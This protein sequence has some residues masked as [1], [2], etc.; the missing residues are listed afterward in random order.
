MNRVHITFGIII[1]ILL[2]VVILALQEVSSGDNNAELDTFAQCLSD[3][4][5]VMYGTYSCPYCRKQKD[6]FGDAFRFVSYVEC[7]QEPD[8]CVADGIDVTPIW[9]FPNDGRL[10]GLQSFEALAAKTG[11]VLLQQ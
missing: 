9:L 3:R 11:C 8:R 10:V 5:A 4:G 1:A 2:I 7:T 6:L